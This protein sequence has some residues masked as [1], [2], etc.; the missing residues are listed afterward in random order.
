[1][2][3]LVW[4]ILFTT[5]I[6]PVFVKAQNDTIKEV[7][8]ND[9]INLFLDCNSCDISFIK[10]K[11][12][13]V[14]YVRDT[15]DADLHLLITNNETA[16]NGSKYF[17]FFIGQK[18]FTNNNDTIE[19]NFDAT[20]TN[21]EIRER[22][23]DK[24]KIGL[25]KYILK[26]PYIEDVLI[27]IKE[28]NPKE[29][30]I[31]DKWNYWVFSINSYININA[32]SQN[33]NFNINSSI[34]ANRTTETNKLSFRLGNSF[35]QQQFEFDDYKILGVNRSFYFSNLYVY[36]LN[37]HFSIGE[38]I[39]INNSTFSNYIYSIKIKPAIEYNFYKYSEYNRRKLCLNYSV[40]IAKN[41][42][43]DTTI[44]FKKNETYGVHSL[45][46]DYQ[47]I[48][49]WGDI[50]LA[51]SGSSILNDFKKNNFNIYSSLN[52][53]IFKGFSINYYISYS[54]IKDQIYLPKGEATKEDVLL[55]LKQLETNYTFWSSI[56]ISYTFGSIY[57]NI[58]NP[59][60]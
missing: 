36:S 44:Y 17:L 38:N 7:L 48:Q 53:R 33:S 51:I 9:A 60:F 28:S 14:N 32:Q 47:N 1:M 10:E 6:Q 40:G 23:L 42:Y 2:K 37:D 4:L 13:L 19:I 15:K 35:N 31:I 54:I 46:I 26:T 22:L 25:I 5:I 58:V 39:N 55:S 49:K 18:T 27:N 45:T 8:R 16:S 3:N 30:K 20:S 29:E 50:Y 56:G 34:N 11:I 52:W 59:R 24:I 12:K 21:K 43:I 57:N 41:K